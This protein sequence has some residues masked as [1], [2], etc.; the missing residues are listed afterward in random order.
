MSEHDPTLV[1][2]AKALDGLKNGFE[3]FKHKN[4]ERIAQIET[5]GEDPITVEVVEK[6]NADM[7]KQQE[8]LDAFE[9]KLRGLSR[10]EQTAD[11]QQIDL[12]K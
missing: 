12:T 3:E 8:V 9:L 7:T 11:G 10:F 6:I 5:R 2:V 1:D 4:D